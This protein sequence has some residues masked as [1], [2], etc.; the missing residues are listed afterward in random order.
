MCDSNSKEIEL[1]E[2]DMADLRLVVQF[3]TADSAVEGRLQSLLVASNCFQ[4]FQLLMPSHPPCLR[5]E[6]IV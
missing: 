4:V 2:V 6:Q 3:C 5:L 1:K